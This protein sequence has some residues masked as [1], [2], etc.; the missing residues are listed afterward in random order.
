VPANVV[1][2]RKGKV[3]FSGE[4]ADLKALERAVSGAVAA[5]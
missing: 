5:K 3:V 4:G 2:D 1:V